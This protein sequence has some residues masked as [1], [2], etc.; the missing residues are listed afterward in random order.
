MEQTKKCSKCGEEKS[1]FDYYK[2][3]AHCKSC[4]REKIKEWQ[5]DN[6]EKVV[7]IKR[8]SAKKHI[9]TK[10]IKNKEYKKNNPQKQSIHK[11]SQIYN[12]TDGYI[13]DLLCNHGNRTVSE[14][15]TKDMI[16]AKREL[17][18]LKRAIYDKKQ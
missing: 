9:K 5:N 7:E 15:I 18:K 14:L 8:R 3:R 13:K 10:R 11:S 16:D 12:L 6:K 17:V 4:V 2:R 1:I